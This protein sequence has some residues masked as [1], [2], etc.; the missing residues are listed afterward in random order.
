MPRRRHNVHLF[1]LAKRGAEVRLR[2]LAEETRHL[3]GLFPHLRDTF[4]RDSLPL[5]FIIAKGAG[6]LKRSSARPRRKRHMSA[7]PRRHG[8]SRHLPRLAE[9]V[10]TVSTLSGAHAAQLT[11]RSTYVLPSA[12]SM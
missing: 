7:A 11:G 2:E 4:G 9:A 8:A 1:E 5:S 12:G 3:I 6:R 10:R